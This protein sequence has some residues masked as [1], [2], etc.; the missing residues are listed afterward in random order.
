MKRAPPQG[1]ALLRWG[2]GPD[3]QLVRGGGTLCSHQDVPLTE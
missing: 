1:G 2:A 3:G